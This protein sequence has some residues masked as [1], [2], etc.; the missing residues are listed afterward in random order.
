M[1]LFK[2]SGK[3]YRKVLAA[4]VHAFQYSPAQVNGDELILLSKNR[5]DCAML[6]RQVQAV[7]KLLRVRRAT[8]TELEAWFPQVRASDRWKYAVEL[9]WIRPL[10]VPFN[11]RAV[12]G[13]NEKRYRP[14]QGFAMLASGDDM[15]VT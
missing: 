9:Y 12:P 8:P 3:T 14:V 13:L 10:P 15:A 5:E 11:L 4:G 7:A 6:E 1:F 2:A